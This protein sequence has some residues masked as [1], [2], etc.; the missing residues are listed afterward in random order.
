[1]RLPALLES[2]M[3]RLH[4]VFLVLA[5]WFTMAAAEVLP[6]GGVVAGS[7][8]TTASAEPGLQGN[9]VEDVVVRFSFPGRLTDASTNP[10]TE[11]TG[12]VTGTVQTRVVLAADGTYDFYW[13]ISLDR[14]SFLPV[15]RLELTDLAPRTYNADWRSDSKGSVS[16]A[17]VAQLASGNVTWAFGQYVP[18]SALIYPGQASYYLFLDSDATAYARST[19]T[20]VSE[21]DGGGSMLV[22]WG[23]A[24]GQLSTFGPADGTGASLS[25]H[26]PASIA[27]TYVKQDP[28]FSQLAT[29]VRSCIV[30]QIA[31]QNAKSSAYGPRGGPFDEA[32]IRAAVQSFAS[33]CR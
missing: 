32:A 18:P 14:R 10:P 15:A 26:S 29:G 23:G 11:V 17:Y 5:A 33:G 24:S 30:S 1:M 21:D 20:L 16:P 19:M 9:V 22:Q 13:Q 2:G 8:G 3:G 7:P 4:C 25:K 28:F 12:D 27:A 6:P 31:Q